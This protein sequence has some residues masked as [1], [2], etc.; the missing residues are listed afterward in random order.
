MTFG[1]LFTGIGGMDLGLERAGMECRWQVEI[2]PFCTKVLERHWPHVK[3]YGDIRAV[4][5]LERVDLI[6]GGFPCQDLSVAGHMGGIDCERS[7]LWREFARIIGALRPRY[8]LIENV[9]GLLANEP[10]RRVLGDL[11]SLGFDAEWESI[12]AAA[13]GAPH[14]RDRVWILAYSRQEHRSFAGGGYDARG[15]PDLFPERVCGQSVE[16][17]KDWELVTLVPG[18]HPGSAADWW[19]R[20]SIVARSVN[21]IPRNVVDSANGAFGNAVVPQVSQWIGRRIIETVT[22]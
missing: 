16:R 18:V 9:S 17:G 8:V 5:E 14:I 15:C 2:D 11:S 4:T 19:L 12:P 1:S 10:M 21:G 3:R 7:G 6:A 20:Q 22:Q 13:V